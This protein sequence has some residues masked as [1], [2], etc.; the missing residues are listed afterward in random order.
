MKGTATQRY[1]WSS[2]PGRPDS[3]KTL[4]VFIREAAEAGYD[5]VE[6]FEEGIGEVAAEYGVRVAGAYA[7]VKCHEGFEQVDPEGETLALAQ[8]VADL[9]GDYLVVNCDPKGAWDNR[10]RKTEDE[11]RRQGENLTRLAEQIA[12]LGLDLVMHNHAVSNDLHMDDLRSV[13]EFAGESVGVC[14][15][16]GWAQTSDD[17]P[18]ARIRALGSRLRA[19]HLRN[20]F[21][22]KPTEW[23]GEGDTDMAE[24]IAALKDIGYEGWLTTEIY[25]RADTDLSASM[26]DNQ[27]RTVALLRELWGEHA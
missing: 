10:E 20:Q 27:T 15:D 5:G 9:G 3:E 16:T 25:Y 2:E 13:T 21:G 26:V 24:C 12:P 14:L 11:L 22:E 7:G 8:A 17:E 1:G 18:I 4:E 19:V 6:G 23:L